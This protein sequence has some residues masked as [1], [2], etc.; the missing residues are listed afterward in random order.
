MF[1]SKYETQS[2][3]SLKNHYNELRS[4]CDSLQREIE[5]LKLIVR[6]LRMENDQL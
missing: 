1:K 4:L 2:Y 5:E 6:Q 3:E